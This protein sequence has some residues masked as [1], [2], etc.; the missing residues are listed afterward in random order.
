MSFNH[1]YS[2]VES[3]NYGYYDNNDYIATQIDSE[4][5]SKLL[6]K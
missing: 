2:Y 1:S 4:S 5:I 3:D 6:W